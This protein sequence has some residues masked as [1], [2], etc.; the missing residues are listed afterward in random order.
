MVRYG[1]RSLGRDFSYFCDDCV[2]YVV[3]VCYCCLNQY[4]CCSLTPK[5]S[6]LCGVTCVVLIYHFFLFVWS[7]LLFLSICVTERYLSVC[8]I[9]RLQCLIKLFWRWSSCCSIICSRARASPVHTSPSAH[10]C[11]ILKKA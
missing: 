5:C 1:S 9:N 3:F 2:V 8:K 4:K 6:I 11:Y 10:S 7:L